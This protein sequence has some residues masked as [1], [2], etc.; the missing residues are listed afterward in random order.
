MQRSFCMSNILISCIYLFQI[1]GNTTTTD[2]QITLLLLLF[3]KWGNVLFPSPQSTILFLLLCSQWII[4]STESPQP[5]EKKTTSSE[6]VKARTSR[7][8]RERYS[9]QRCLEA[10]GVFFWLK[11]QPDSSV[12]LRVKT[13]TF[14]VYCSQ[15]EHISYLLSLML[16]ARFTFSWVCP[17]ACSSGNLSPTPPPDL[18]LESN[19]A[20]WVVA[21]DK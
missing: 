8:L 11:L 3:V 7:L 20:C 17:L 6:C 18:D 19:K 1:K 2:V 21:L 9:G 12:S 13:K 15:L 10:S 14:G 5:P 4:R 16:Q